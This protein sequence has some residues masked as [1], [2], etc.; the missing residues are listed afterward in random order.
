MMPFDNKIYENI[1][2]RL[3]KKNFVFFNYLILKNFKAMAFCLE[4]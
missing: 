4:S 3:K 2:L 1:L